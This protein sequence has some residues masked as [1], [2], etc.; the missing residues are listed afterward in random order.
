LLVDP[1]V[2]DNAP[3]SSIFV[4]EDSREWFEDQELWPVGIF[5]PADSEFSDAEDAE[6]AVDD[7]VCDTPHT[8]WDSFSWPNYSQIEGTDVLAFNDIDSSPEDQDSS[9]ETSESWGDTINVALLHE[10]RTTEWD[11]LINTSTR[12][13]YCLAN[14]ATHARYSRF[15]IRMKKSKATIVDSLYRTLGDT[16]LSHG[17]QIELCF[18]FPHNRRPAEVTVRDA[19]TTQVV[20]LPQDANIMALMSYLDTDAFGPISDMQLWYVFPLYSLISV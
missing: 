10:G 17:G 7:W 9:E 12:T 20:F 3:D 18:T 15:T 1:V 19:S 13:L 16:D 8:S 2:P 11:L 6:A 4:N 5:E 14:R